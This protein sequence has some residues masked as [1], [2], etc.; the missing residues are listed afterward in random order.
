MLAG[1][2]LA[3][4]QGM[5]E[6]KAREMAVKASNKAHAVYG[7]ASRQYWAQGSDPA[8]RIGQV[9][10]TFLKFPQNYLNLLYDLGWDK[11]N[12]KAFTWALAAP[13]VL[14][15]AA[16]IPFKDNIVWMINALMKGLDDDRDIEKMVFDDV[17]LHFGKE[18]EK[19]IRTGL[20]GALGMDITGSLSMNLGLPTDLL[21][22]TGIFGGMAKETYRAGH[23]IGTK[24]YSKAL[25]TAL[26]SGI[27]NLFKAVRELDGATTATGKQVWNDDGTPYIPSTGETAL[28]VFGFRGSTRTTTQQRAWEGTREAERWNDSRGK[29]YE[30]YRAYLVKKNKN[31]DE[32]KSLM[33][34]IY[35]FNKAIVATGKVGLVSFIKPA[36]LKRQARAMLIQPKAERKKTMIGNS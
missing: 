11:R 21:S 10:T 14:G 13:I 23:F 27:A 19:N 34:D 26:P 25:E 36:Q 35:K 33:Q 5:S 28:R 9:A 3:K 17:R 18:T 24:Q 8:A 32:F 12:I 1:Y 7:K 29:I 6:T 16:A 20:M 2:R 15:G 4:Q 22:L 31:P 30:K